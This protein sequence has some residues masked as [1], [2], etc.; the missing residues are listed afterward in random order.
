[1]AVTMALR[2]RAWGR[3]ISTSTR[4][5]RRRSPQNRFDWPLGLQQHPKC[6]CDKKC[7]APRIAQRAECIRMK[8]DSGGD[9]MELLGFAIFLIGLALFVIE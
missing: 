9:D 1:M 6:A 8:C 3:K 7:E 5:L 2:A 4:S